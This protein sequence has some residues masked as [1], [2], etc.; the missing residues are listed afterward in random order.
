[1]YIVWCIYHTRFPRIYFSA[2]IHPWTWAWTLELWDL[3]LNLGGLVRLVTEKNEKSWMSSQSY[4]FCRNSAEHV[5][6][7]WRSSI[8]DSSTML[9]IPATLRL[10]SS[11]VTFRK[12]PS[13]PIWCRDPAFANTVWRSHARARLQ[14]LHAQAVRFFIS[15]LFAGAGVVKIC[16][17]NCDQSRRERAHFHRR[18]WTRDNSQW[19]EFMT[20]H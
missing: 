2:S 8:H 6:C 15:T 1:M 3:N 19:Q 9:A 13:D 5:M 10:E 7:E 18:W 16:E 20:R 4:N 17:W 14:W 12:L 11:A